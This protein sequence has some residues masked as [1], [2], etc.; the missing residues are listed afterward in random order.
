MIAVA[1]L[2][3][4]TNAFAHPGWSAICVFFDSGGALNIY[5]IFELAELKTTSVRRCLRLYR[6]VFKH[7]VFTVPLLPLQR[8]GVVLTMRR[9]DSCLT[10]YLF[11]KRFELSITKD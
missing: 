9:S 5:P 10:W 3:L 2:Y 1:V 7:S 4:H 8:T 6:T 11:I